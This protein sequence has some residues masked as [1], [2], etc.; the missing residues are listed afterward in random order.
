LS[1]RYHH[2]NKK[3]DTIVDENNLT[4]TKNEFTSIKNRFTSIFEVRDLN[5]PYYASYSVL[6][7]KHVVDPFTGDKYISFTMDNDKTMYDLIP[8]KENLNFNNVIYPNYL[9][10]TKVMDGLV[11]KDTPD[12]LDSIEYSRFEHMNNVRRLRKIKNYLG[13]EGI[14]IINTYPNN[15]MVKLETHPHYSTYPVNYKPLIYIALK[16]DPNFLKVHHKNIESDAVSTLEAYIIK[17]SIK[18]TINE[19]KKDLDTLIKNKD[20]F[21]ALSFAELMYENNI[22]YVKNKKLIK[23]LCN[24]VDTV[25]HDKDWNCRESYK[26]LMKTLYNLDSPSKRSKI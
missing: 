19:Y 7:V 12:E 9:N 13:K 8:Y 18:K 23:S 21:G 10:I 26:K 20:I 16:Y 6:D 17:M 2:L 3:Y 4:S 14:D 24:Y 1:Y 25:K 11:F 5:S 15:N 22:P